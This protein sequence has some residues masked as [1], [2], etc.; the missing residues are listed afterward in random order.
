MAKLLRINMTDRSAV[1]QD[2]PEAYKLLGGRG[3]TSTIVHD[4]VDPLCHPLG[5]CNK[6]VFAPGIVTGTA[7]PTSARVSVGGK[8]P[9]TGGI[10]EANA[11][12]GWAPA[13]ADLNIQAI[14]VE[15]QPAQAGEWWGLFISWDGVKDQPVVEWFDAGEYVGQSTYDF[16]PQLF[17]RFGRAAGGKKDVEQLANFQRLESLEQRCNIRG[18]ALADESEHAVRRRRA[19]HV[20]ERFLVDGR[21]LHD[22]LE[23][24]CLSFVNQ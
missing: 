7:A 1:M 3:L 20:A 17:E 5:P 9:L 11:G 13:L 23:D 19:Q 12:S 15:G 6:L 2:V 22:S 18:M 10:K 24:R 14:V 16:Y 8:S 21:G 4:E